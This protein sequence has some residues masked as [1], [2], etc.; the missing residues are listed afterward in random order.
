MGDGH[1]GAG[2]VVQEALQP[3]HGFGIQVVGRFVQQQHVRAFPA[4]DGT[5]PRGGAHHRRGA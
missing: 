2:V 1:D 5:G 4:A 3:G